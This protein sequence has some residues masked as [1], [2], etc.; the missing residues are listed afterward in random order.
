M[1]LREDLGPNEVLASIT[2]EGDDTDTVSAIAGTILGARYGAA[3]IP[4]ERLLDRERIEKY[5][6]ALVTK[7]CPE[8][9]D[10][11]MEAER[12]WTRESNAFESS[13]RQRRQ[14]A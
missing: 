10:E 14:E 9:L 1:S 4:V 5:A 8:S 13:L 12:A 3:W 6:T 7:Q 2:C 11:F